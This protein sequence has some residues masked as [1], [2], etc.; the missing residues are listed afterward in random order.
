MNSLLHLRMYTEL[1]PPR[2]QR[3][4]LDGTLQRVPARDVHI[5]H[6]HRSADRDVS[7][8]GTRIADVPG[9]STTRHA[10]AEGAVTSISTPT[11]VA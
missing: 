6:G 2:L 8:G 7:Q 9:I 4:A 1:V 10:E 11:H 5:R 3:G